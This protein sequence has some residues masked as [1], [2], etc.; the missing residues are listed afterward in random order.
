MRR[1]LSFD[2]VSALVLA[3]DTNGDGRV[4]CDELTRLLHPEECV[5]G[6][7]D[8][9]GLREDAEADGSSLEGVGDGDVRAHGHDASKCEQQRGD[10]G[11]AHVHGDVHGESAIA[12]GGTPAGPASVERVADESET[13]MQ[14]LAAAR[15]VVKENCRHEA[16]RSKD[17]VPIPR[18]HHGLHRLSETSDGE[19]DDDDDEDDDEDGDEDGDESFEEEEACDEEEAIAESER[20]APAVDSQNAVAHGPTG[21][22]LGIEVNEMMRC[23]GI[24]LQDVAVPLHD[25]RS[26]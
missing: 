24:E 7:E 16:K 17:V 13:T 19:F 9:L 12:G 22:V 4:T 23:C 5:D 10:V 11:R 21:H 26:A 25:E 20:G 15:R 3:L 8:E 14:W 6:I 2:Q 1:C 18:H